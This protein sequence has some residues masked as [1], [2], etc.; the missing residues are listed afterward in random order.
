MIQNFINKLSGK[1]KKFL[2]IT[3]AIVLLAFFDNLFLRPSLGKLN[4]L[5]DL[6]EQQEDRIIRDLRILSYK[7]EILKEKKAYD[8]YFIEEM[9]NDD[10]INADFLA[11][12]ERLSV[13]N[14]VKLVKSGPSEIKK[15][16]KYIEYYA[17]IDC[18][19][20]MDDVISFIHAINSTDELLK[21]VSLIMLPKRGT[22]RD[23][24]ATMA[25]SKL[26]ISLD[27]INED[28]DH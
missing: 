6:I 9:G 13:D 23:V 26:F 12:I 24:S 25:V 16:K 10:V 11:I 27:M 3:I 8:K 28:A 15:Y 21:V 18:I 17:N 4:E 14:K 2:Y 5:N 1:E 19:G 22:P 7:K 20:T